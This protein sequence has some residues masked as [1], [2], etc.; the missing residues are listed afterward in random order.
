MNG[1]KSKM[2]YTGIGDLIEENIALK[3][4]LRKQ[5]IDSIKNLIGIFKLCFPDYKKENI[6][7]KGFSIYDAMSGWEKELK[8][9]QDLEQ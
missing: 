8:K 7:R 5:K 6:K 9:Y 3:R 2:K 4:R 1:K